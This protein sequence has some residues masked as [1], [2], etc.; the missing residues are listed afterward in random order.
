MTQTDTSTRPATETT[1]DVE[2]ARR[3]RLELSLVQLFAG[4]LAAM[5]AAVIGSRL[6]V[7]GT[8]VGAALGSLVAGVAGS[9]YSAS[10]QRGRQVIAKAPLTVRAAPTVV[11]RTRPTASLPTTG[12]VP[13]GVPPRATPAG[14]EPRSEPRLRRRAWK[15]ALAGAAAVFVLAGLGITALELATGQSLSGREGTTI[16]DVGG[17]AAPAPQPQDDTPAEAPTT[18]DEPTDESSETPSGTTETPSEMPAETP[19]ETPTEDPTGTPTDGPSELP[20]ESPSDE[21][22]TPPTPEP[23]E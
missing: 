16:S 2:P 18:E 12:A 11:M 10:L 8:V 21:P 23:S 13:P 6:G 4:A 20:S 1:D 14:G 15:P 7:S 19:S 17:G 9:V 5:T 22:S 3:S